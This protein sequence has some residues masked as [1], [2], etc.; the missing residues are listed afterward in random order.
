MSESNG[1]RRRFLLSAGGAAAFMWI[2][3]HVKGYT[4]KEMRVWAAGETTAATVSKWDLDTPALCLDLDK[5][6]KNFAKA[7]TTLAENGIKPRPH[8]KTHKC[9]AI[10]KLQIADG[11]VG[12]STAKVSESEAMIDNGVDKVLQTTANVTPH[13]IRRAMELRKRCPGFIQSVDTAENA[14]ELSD[15]AGEAGIVADVVVDVDPGMQRTGIAAGDPAV[16]LARLVDSL[17]GLRLRGMEAYDGASQHV[18]GFKERRAKT[19]ERMAAPTETYAMLEKAG[20]NTEIF[21][22]G[23]TGTYNIDHEHRSLTDVQCGSY[24]FMDAQYLAISSK[25]DDMVYS[26]FL[27]SLTVLT[28]VL[29]TNFEGRATADAGAKSM[30]INEPDPIVYGETG[31]SYRARSD[32]FGSI[33]YD[34]PSR[35]YKTGDKLELIVPHCDPVVNLYD[36]INGIRNGVVETV[37]PIHARGKSQ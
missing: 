19:M 17:P 28:T 5:M 16:E 24:L 2:P 23:G 13:K 1:S 14:R 4:A 35:T 18:K 29:N 7:H 33:R 31:I 21:S 30:T 32:E 36:Q 22:G 15:A 34:N 27:P 8:A 3:R 10:A 25:N 20:L 11:A 6:E 12:I 26:D 9:P 37:W